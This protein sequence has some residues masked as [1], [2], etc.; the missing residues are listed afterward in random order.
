MNDQRLGRGLAAIFGDESSI[1][2]PEDTTV[3][4][5]IDSIET[6]EQQPRKFFDEIK[7]KELSDSITKYG[8]LQPLTV[9]RKGNVY[10][11]LAGERRLRAAKAAGLRE[12]PVYAVECTANDTIVLALIENLQRADLNAIEEAEAFKKLIEDHKCTQENL[13][14][15]LCKSR[16]YIANALR[17]L[18][19]PDPVRGMVRDGRLSSGHAKVLVGLKDSEE[20][21]TIAINNKMSVRT[22]EQ[23]IKARKNMKKNGET[24]ME[25]YINPDEQEIAERLSGVL[26]LKTKLKISENGGMLTIYCN[27]Y[28][29]LESLVQTLS[30]ITEP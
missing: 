11:L 1:I 19:L 28:E 5:D 17:L 16:S 20:I 12:V 13:A 23:F 22:L 14:L 9:R 29:Q 3:M 24:P 7:L 2:N 8:L 25:K 26:G 4:V 10:E 18:S 6:N 15:I 27:T 30:A 21:A